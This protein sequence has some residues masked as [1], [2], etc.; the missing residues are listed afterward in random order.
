MINE[1]LIISCTVLFRYQS[2]ILFC[3]DWCNDPSHQIAMVTY[4]PTLYFHC[5]WY[6]VLVEPQ[7]II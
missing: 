5:K 7:N 1:Y 3:S 6:V 2:G 4:R